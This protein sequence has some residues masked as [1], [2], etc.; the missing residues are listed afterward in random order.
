MSSDSGR[1]S[2][3][4]KI[5]AFAMFVAIFYVAFIILRW[6]VTT[7]VGFVCGCILAVGLIVTGMMGGFGPSRAEMEWR[8]RVPIPADNRRMTS[9]APVYV[10]PPASPP[11]RQVDAPN[12]TVRCTGSGITELCYIRTW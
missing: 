11:S 1:L 4:E 3:S 5:V 2:L 6:M 10:P 8:E 12:L 7:K 9:P